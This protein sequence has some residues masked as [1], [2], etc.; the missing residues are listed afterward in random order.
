M[1]IVKL[2]GELLASSRLCV[3]LETAVNNSGSAT[4]EKEGCMHRG[5]LGCKLKHMEGVQM[6]NN[7]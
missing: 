5:A 3:W 1:S 4:S 2:T 6:E 7:L